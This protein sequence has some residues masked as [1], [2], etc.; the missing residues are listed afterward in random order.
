MRRARRPRGDGSGDYT[1]ERQHRQDQDG[2]STSDAVAALG[3]EIL[4]DQAAGQV[5]PLSPRTRVVR[6][7]V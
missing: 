4:R 5:G 1:A 7:E 6:Q 2:P 3:E